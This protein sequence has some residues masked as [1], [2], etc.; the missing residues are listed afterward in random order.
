MIDLEKVK[1]I[2][3]IENNDGEVN[4]LLNSGY[5]IVHIKTEKIVR[6][7]PFPELKKIQPYDLFITRVI[8]GKINQ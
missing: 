3:T 5:K 7:K 1:Q 2:R 4:S 8:L 6:Y